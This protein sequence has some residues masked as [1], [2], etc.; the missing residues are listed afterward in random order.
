MNDKSNIPIVYIELETYEDYRK[1][2]IKY[3]ELLNEE[4][5]LL[6][7][8]KRAQKEYKDAVEERK[9][10]ECKVGEEN[11]KLVEAMDIEKRS[12]SHYNA[13]LKRIE[14]ISPILGV[15]SNKL[16]GAKFYDKKILCENIRYLIKEKG[17][18]LGDI[19]RSSGNTV[20]YMS[21]LEKE[22]NMS[23]PNF[24][25]IITAASMLKTTI[26][27]LL[28]SDLAQAT[29]TEK[30]ILKFLTKLAKDTVKDKLEWIE[31]KADDLKTIETYNEQAE[32]PMFSVKYIPTVPN[33]S[34]YPDYEEVVYF[35][36]DSFGD[37]TKILG[38]C[39]NIRLKN[40]VF[41]YLMDVCT[42]DDPLESVVEIWMY[43]PTEKKYLCKTSNENYLSDIAEILHSAVV[44]NLKHP[45]ISK[46]MKN[47][48]DAFMNDDLEDAP[49]D[50]DLPFNF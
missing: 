34:G 43:S 12:E 24:D 6:K 44:E 41:V 17:V 42:E 22:D 25:F 35:D 38:S 47:S 31:E 1:A 32:H 13:L 50:D 23:A 7:E 4:N 8:I 10:V 9:S 20:G 46:T 15:Y 48:M 14:S 3:N 45:K 11:P 40:G 27:E 28:Y 26:E 18:K 37:N 36:S 39:Y 2:V 21:R 33:S 30:Y 29:E 49:L 16:G 5:Q 19:E